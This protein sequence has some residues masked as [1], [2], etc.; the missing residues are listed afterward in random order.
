MLQTLTTALCPGAYKP[1]DNEGGLCE[2]Q[3]SICS[4]RTYLIHLYKSHL[5]FLSIPKETWH[6]NSKYISQGIIYDSLK[7]LQLSCKQK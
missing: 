5:S 1:P 7:T 2:M 4:Q 3:V 6:Q